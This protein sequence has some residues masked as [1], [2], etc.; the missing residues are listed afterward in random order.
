LIVPDQSAVRR[1]AAFLDLERGRD[2]LFELPRH[3]CRY[4]D[5]CSG[6]LL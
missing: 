3:C 4:V 6:D 1:E 2:N 5:S